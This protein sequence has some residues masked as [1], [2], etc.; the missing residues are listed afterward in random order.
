MFTDD[1]NLKVV[2]KVTD[3]P[4]A[5]FYSG[6]V[7]NYIVSTLIILIAIMLAPKYKE[8]ILFVSRIFPLIQSHK[9]K[10]V[11]TVLKNNLDAND[12]TVIVISSSVLL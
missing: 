9:L 2:D 6:R 5:I 4:V 11:S 1:N 12:T 7:M 10:T 3:S 8:T